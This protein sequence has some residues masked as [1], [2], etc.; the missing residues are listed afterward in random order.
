MNIKFIGKV[1]I[2]NIAKLAIYLGA[3]I[4]AGVPQRFAVKYDYIPNDEIQYHLVPSTSPNADSCPVIPMTHHRGNELL[5][6]TNYNQYEYAKELKIQKGGWW[7]PDS[8]KHVHNSV[9]VV[10]FRGRHDQLK[11]FL[12]YIHPFLQKQLI[13]YRIIV[14]EQTFHKP[15]NRGY[16]LNIGFTEALKIHPFH[17]FIFHDVD[18]LPMVEMNMYACTYKPRHLCPAINS[19]RYKLKYLTAFGGVVA[20]LREHFQ[21]I[22]GFSNNYY[23]WGG[24]DDDLM[25]RVL[26]YKLGYCRFSPDVSK[27]N[28]LHHKPEEKNPERINILQ[29]AQKRF[30]NDGLTSLN[31]TNLEYEEKPLFTHILVD[32][33]STLEQATALGLS[34]WCMNTVEGTVKG[35]LE[36][37]ADKIELMKHWLQYKGSPHSKIDKVTFTN[38]EEIESRSF[39]RFFIK[40]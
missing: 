3:F 40:H 22:N 35:V 25:Q 18:L 2:T 32:L 17:C 6:S 24:E 12:H 33:R 21:I 5:K 28:M 31:Y 37:D 29:E 34:G 36:G 1:S 10:P 15:F 23:G 11:I 26:K 30:K 13:S 4:Y 8:C 38:Q 19:W 16:L 14:V 27:Y 7:Q 9:I 39:D 20:I